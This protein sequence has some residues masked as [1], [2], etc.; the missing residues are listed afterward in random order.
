MGEKTGFLT[1]LLLFGIA[2]LPLLFNTYNSQVKTAKLLTIS[3]EMQQLVASEGGVT[4]RVKNA[5]NKL[6]DQGVD[7][8]FKDK[9]GNTV[10]G[11]VA[12]GETVIMHYDYDGFKTS[13]STII[14][15][16]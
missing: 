1:V 4:D 11:K 15:K 13:N 14:M 6:K 10:N 12:V 3:N 2:I 8:T 5:V 7:I 9:N 16:R